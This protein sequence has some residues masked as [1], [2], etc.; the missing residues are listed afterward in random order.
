MKK[1]IKEKC[2]SRPEQNVFVFYPSCALYIGGTFFSVSNLQ[3]AVFG[4]I[5]E[6]KFLTTLAIV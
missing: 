6:I 3:K 5:S 2:R 4:F 1:R